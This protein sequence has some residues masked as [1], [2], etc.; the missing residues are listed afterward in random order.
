[1]TTTCRGVR[2]E[3]LPIFYS[4]NTFALCFGRIGVTSYEKNIRNAAFLEWLADIGPHNVQNLRHVELRFGRWGAWH[5][6]GAS[7]HELWLA[8]R[9]FAQPF[10]AR[11][12]D[13]MVRFTIE[14]QSSDRHSG[15]AQAALCFPVFLPERTK[16]I[17]RAFSREHR[18]IDNEG[19]TIALWRLR[20]FVLKMVI[21]GV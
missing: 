8:I 4:M 3:S 16:D 6:N 2:Q 5:P 1:M 9:P 14:Y 13:F 12:V 15:P 20:E 18:Q 11:D 17:A 19:N 7:A 10:A 21:I